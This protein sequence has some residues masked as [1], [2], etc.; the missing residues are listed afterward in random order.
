MMLFLSPT[1]WSFSTTADA[2]EELVEEMQQPAG[3]A[4]KN[5]HGSKA[6]P[7]MFKIRLKRVLKT[8]VFFLDSPGWGYDN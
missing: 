4:W 8:M 7:R 2:R 5:F 6:I 3:L 1:R